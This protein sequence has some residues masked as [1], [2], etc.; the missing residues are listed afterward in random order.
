MIDQRSDARIA[1]DIALERH[2]NKQIKIQVKSDRAAFLDRLLA[3]GDWSAV[4][5]L[6]KKRKSNAIVLRDLNGDI[7]SSNA[8]AETLAQYLENA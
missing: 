4:R 7:F 8:N 2:L 6:R 5:A 3:S 1:N